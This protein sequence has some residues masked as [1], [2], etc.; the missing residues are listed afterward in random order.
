MCAP[1]ITERRP[2]LYIIG[3]YGKDIHKQKWNVNK[4]LKYVLL[5]LFRCL[6]VRVRGSVL[7]TWS[8]SRQETAGFVSALRSLLII[9]QAATVASLIFP[10]LLHL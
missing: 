7:S 10:G 1:Q 5:S 2:L 8:S 4:Y 9:L 3:H 6:H